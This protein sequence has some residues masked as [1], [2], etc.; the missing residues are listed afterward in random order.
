M[1]KLPFIYKFRYLW[2]LLAVVGVGIMTSQLPKLK[3]DNSMTI[4]FVED[5]PTLVAYDSFLASFGSDEV[6]ITVIDSSGLARPDAIKRL[7][8]LTAGLRDIAGVGDVQNLTTIKTVGDQQKSRVSK[9]FVG[10]NEAVLLVY[11]WMEALPD[12]DLK[13]PKILTDIDK[14]CSL[15]F[16]EDTTVWHAGVG[17]VTEALN[18]AFLKESAVFTPGSYLV[19]MVL[20]FYLTRS[21]RWV[22][23]ALTTV[24]FANVVLFASMPLLGRPLT[25]ISIAL[26]PLILISSVANI[27]HI[28]RHIRGA[29]AEPKIDDIWQRFQL[30]IKPCI[31]N[32]LT[33]AGGFFSLMLAKMAITRDYGLFAGIAILSTLLFSTITSMLVLRHGAGAEADSRGN[34]ATAMVKWAVGHRPVVLVVTAVALAIAYSGIAQLRADTYSIGFLPKD[35]V[36]R[37]SSVAIEK[38]AGNYLPLEFTVGISNVDS[39]NSVAFVERLERAESKLISSTP[40]NRGSI[41]AASV[42]DLREALAHLPKDQSGSQAVQSILG[43]TGSAAFWDDAKQILRL[44]YAVPMAS[45]ATLAANGNAIQA[46]LGEELAEYGTVQK[47]GYLPLYSRLAENLITDQVTSIVAA[48]LCISILMAVFLRSWRLLGLAIIVNVLPILGILGVMGH[49][50]IALD[51]ATITIAP[52]MLG[53]IV[54][55]TLHL[56]YH[57][58]LSLREG[59][60]YRAAFI[61]ATEQTGSALLATSTT[62]ALGFGV[63]GFAGIE[64]I[65]VTG[66]LMALTVGLALATDL[67]LLPVLGSYLYNGSAL[68][69]AKRVSGSKP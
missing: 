8:K 16:G 67:L 21:V 34:L 65:A 33:T 59:H 58:R 3:I 9:R 52:A 22:L 26:P 31:F 60:D 64:S 35:H 20:L 63:L 19:V 66:T 24:I 36:V 48:L 45:A 10:K 6:V 5:D 56:L 15:H 4:W 39:L 51:I 40:V 42:F 12:L 68:A 29:H 43:A 28:S 54:D 23:A 53:I 7:E 37:Q 55:D 69:S 50:A 1:N 38:E 13:R 11:T 49:A 2:L 17:V 57:L 46:I 14:Q 32:A 30:V 47:N 61:T 27:L 41:F 44:S 62:L 25:V 18:Q